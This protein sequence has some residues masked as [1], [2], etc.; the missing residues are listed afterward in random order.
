MNGASLMH[1]LVKAESKWKFSTSSTGG[2][3]VE[4]VAVEGG[5]IYLKDPAGALQTFY[6]GSAGAG[7]AWGAKLPKLGK[8]ELRVRGKSVGGVIAPSA[9]PNTGVVY[10]MDSFK[11]S[12]LSRSDITGACI[13]VEV[14]GGLIL[15]GSGTAMLLGVNP[16]WLAA[17]AAM[18]LLAGPELIGL[19]HSARGLLL[20]TG[21]NAG[22]IAGGGAGAFVGGL[23]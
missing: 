17:L 18:P 12:E 19:V 14:Y 11:G 7:A 2:L 5:A 10:V 22:V 8:I 15:G 4:F 1:V 16:V 20:M 3:G 21:F 6:Y 13:F 9:L 23:F